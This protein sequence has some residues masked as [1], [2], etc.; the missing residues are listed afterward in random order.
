MAMKLRAAGRTFTILE[1]SDEI[2]GTWHENN[3]PGVACDV[4]AHLYSFSDEPN[5]YWSH[6]YA[7]GDEIQDYLLSV[8][9]K[10]Q[11]RQHILFG[12]ALTQAMFDEPSGLW[13]VSYADAAGHVTQVTTTALVLGVG[14]LHVPYVPQIPGLHEF[15]G[16]LIHTASWPQDVSMFGRRVG[17]I[18]TGASA[19]QCVPPLAE[20][21]S[22][23]TVFQRTPSWILP[24]HNTEYSEGTIDRFRRRPKW[25]KAHRQALRVANDLRSVAFD[26]HPQL[27]QVASR[28]A[29]AHLRNQVK[30][31]QLRSQLAPDYT[32]GCKRVLLSDTYYP[33]LCRQDVSLVTDAIVAATPEGLVTDDGTLHE[34]D[35]IVLATGFDP[36]GSYRH[37]NIF[38]ESGRSF[39]D[40]WEHGVETYLGITMAHFPNFFMLLGPNTGLGHTSVIGMIEAQVRHI[41]ALLDERDARDASAVAVRPELVMAFTQQMAERSSRSVWQAGGCSSWYLDSDGVNRTLWPGSVREYEQRCAQTTFIDYVFSPRDM[42][43]DATVPIPAFESH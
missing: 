20:D 35:V 39:A 28:A 17:V 25:M 29:L 15:A 11:L 32:M 22:H 40:E 3:Y 38:G 6:K 34:L 24:R 26:S 18:G 4:P 27:L 36:T 30:D 9:E 33:A 42:A 13:H 41:L 19:I 10:H 2:G 12:S 8:V 1:K 14:A 21:A 23:L 16:Q 43:A 31:S 37:L 7:S 5:P